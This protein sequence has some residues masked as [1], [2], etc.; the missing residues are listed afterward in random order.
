MA[1]GDEEGSLRTVK[2]QIASGFHKEACQREPCT[3]CTCIIDLLADQDDRQ[4]LSQ[5]AGGEYVQEAPG[6]H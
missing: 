1:I 5:E 2:C 4:R 3:K 6:G